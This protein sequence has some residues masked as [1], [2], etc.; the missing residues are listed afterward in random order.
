MSRG[1]RP[2]RRRRHG[3]RAV[4]AGALVVVLAALVYVPVVLLAPL[5]PATAAAA[6]WTAPAQP[7]AQLTF[8]SYGATAVQAVGWDESLT[9][10]GS[11]T[12]LPIASISKVVTA[13]VVLDA[14]P[15]DG[16]DGPSLTLDADDVALYEA[17]RS[18]DGKVAPM[19]LGQQLTEKQMLQVSLIESANNYAD[20]LARWAFGDTAGFVAAATAWLSENGLTSTTLVEPTGMSPSN[21]STATDLV[22]LGEIAL[23][24]P[25][26]AAIV[27]TP[28][29]TVPG[30]GVIENSNELLGL[31]GVVGIKTGT[32]D[33]AGACLLFAADYTIAGE[34]VTVVGVMLG[35]VD[36]DSLDADVQR[37]LT[38]VSGAFQTVT[39]TTAGD[40]WASYELPWGAGTEAVAAT[41]AS[42]LVWG[43]V[44][45][46]ASIETESVTTGAAGDDVGRVRFQIGDE[47]VDVPLVLDRALAE[48]DAWWRLTHPDEVLAAG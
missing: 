37:L 24:D 32:L 29:T 36:H 30:V 3:V 33:E 5:A 40:V 15:L 2:A 27:A 39:A 22:R 16:G 14:R 6:E 47:E 7:G 17:Y 9:T 1:A 35:G 26:V 43:D 18:Q 38:S 48:P 4:V 23:A 46:T 13:L 10:S 31:D 44:T 8:P 25:E 42:R 11:T 41:D 12:P 20:A 45:V 28:T 21:T 19:A 34:S